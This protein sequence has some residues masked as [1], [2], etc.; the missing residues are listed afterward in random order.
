[1]LAPSLLA[2]CSICPFAPDVPAELLIRGLAVASGTC[3]LIESWVCATVQI[4][5]LVLLSSLS[6]PARHLRN[7]PYQNP[8][9][10]HPLHDADHLLEG[11]FHAYGYH[12]VL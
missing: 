4:S 1:M 10:A 12:I 9:E 2:C 3:G 6:W 8:A 11:T 5:A 7:L